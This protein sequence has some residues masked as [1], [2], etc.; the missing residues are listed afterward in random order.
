MPSAS[1]GDDQ[2]S[3]RSKLT[4]QIADVYVESAIPWMQFA[5][6]HFRGETLAGHHRPRRR[7]KT[8]QDFVLDRSKVERRA[9]QEHLPAGWLTREA[10]DP[11]QDDRL[12][13]SILCDAR[14]ELL[15]YEG[16]RGWPKRA[17][18][19]YRVAGR[20]F[21]QPRVRLAAHQLDE[22]VA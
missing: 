3:V 8:S 9:F 12:T 4:P 1:R 11:A 20:D 16:R 17:L 14:A 5:P 22:L 15:L 2:R 6:E 18:V 10:W 21:E 7:D 13:A 19:T